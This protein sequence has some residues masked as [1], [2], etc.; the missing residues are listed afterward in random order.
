MNV[1]QL[2]L[3]FTGRITR[4]SYWLGFATVVAVLG[5][6]RYVLKYHIG[7]TELPVVVWSTLAAVPLTALNVK[8][9][10]D[11]DRPIWIG[12]VV[13]AGTA[14]F[15]AAPYFGY[16]TDDLAHYSLVEHVL[17]WGLLP[18]SVFALVDNGFLRGTRGENRYGPD[19]IVAEV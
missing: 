8:R 15:I 12:Y 9:F 14:L 1:I 7:A 18:L 13:G 2:F 17:L 10:N 3:G 6:G 16:L 19:P 4:L 5:L 11:R